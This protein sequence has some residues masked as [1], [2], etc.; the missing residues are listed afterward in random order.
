M[1]GH[2]VI[3]GYYMA[4]ESRLWVECIAFLGVVY[5][6]LEWICIILF[7][8]RSSYVI[9]FCSRQHPTFLPYIIER[10]PKY[11]GIRDESIFFRHVIF[12]R[13]WF[14]LYTNW[15]MSLPNSCWVIFV[16]SDIIFSD[17][18][19]VSCDSAS[20]RV[21]VKLPLREAEDILLTLLIPQS[22]LCCHLPPLS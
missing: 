14:A 9:I 4:V 5:M 2:H 6:P 11:L 8:G 7:Y 20:F 12:F 21:I 18:Q 10:I 1:I 16:V 19:F 17:A 15:Y 3:Y 22:V 13:G